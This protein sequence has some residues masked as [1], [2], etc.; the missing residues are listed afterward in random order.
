M[1]GGI[2]L[3]LI[4]ILQYWLTVEGCIMLH[5]QWPCYDFQKLFDV[6]SALKIYLLSRL[7]INFQTTYML[8]SDINF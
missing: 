6:L 8:M 4:S 3:Y 2:H 1:I 5:L 7:E